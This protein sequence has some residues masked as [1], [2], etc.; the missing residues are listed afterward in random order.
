MK[1]VLGIEEA[2]PLPLSMIFSD[3]KK[4]KNKKNLNMHILRICF[5]MNVFNLV[6]GM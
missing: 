4:V 5:V 6:I 2:G 1:H 3:N